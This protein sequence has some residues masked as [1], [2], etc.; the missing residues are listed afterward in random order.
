ML[1]GEFY[2]LPYALSFQFVG[3]IINIEQRVTILRQLFSINHITSRNVSQD[4]Y[5]S[6]F[7]DY[8]VFC[9]DGVLCQFL[10]HSL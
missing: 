3:E 5:L 2:L 10:T 4:T 6:S 9:A 7:I 1:Q 8:L